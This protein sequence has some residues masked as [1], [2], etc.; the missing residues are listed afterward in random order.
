LEN[1]KQLRRRG[2]WFSRQDRILFP[3]TQRGREFVHPV[4]LVVCSVV[5]HSN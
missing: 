4:V 1:W 3:Q 2:E 5:V